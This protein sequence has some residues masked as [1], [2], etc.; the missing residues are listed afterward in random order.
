MEPVVVVV[1]VAAAA[2]LS[3]ILEI[4]L[5]KWSGPRTLQQ[6]YCVLRWCWSCLASAL[7]ALVEK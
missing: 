1:A 7:A 2:V 5:H 4:V 3:G 6:L